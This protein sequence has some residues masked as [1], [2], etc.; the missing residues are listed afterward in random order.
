MKRKMEKLSGDDRKRKAKLTAE[1][2]D[3]LLKPPEIYM[4]DDGL[5]HIVIKP[6]RYFDT[7]QMLPRDKF[8]DVVE[9]EEK[10]DEEEEDPGK[11]L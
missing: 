8:H 7:G 3:E 11:L 2:L 9:Y 4:G 1:Y 5:R 10:K 6:P